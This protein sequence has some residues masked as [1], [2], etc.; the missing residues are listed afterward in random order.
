MDQ[1]KALLKSGDIIVRDGNDEVSEAARNFNRKDKS[2]SHCGIIQIEHDTVFVYHALGGSFNP[3]QKLLRQ[4]LNI[5]CHPKEVNKFAVF[6]YELDIDEDIRLSD[7]IH[8][9]YVEGLP[10]DLFFNFY[11]DD[12]MYCS[13][14]VFKAINT[15]TNGALNK[16]LQKEGGVLY[17]TIDDLYLNEGAKEVVEVGF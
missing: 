16:Y 11:T 3:S 1:A 7:W 5:F 4:P 6:R 10:F 13:E 2:Y 12:K 17:V 9:S 8:R 14:F 15:A